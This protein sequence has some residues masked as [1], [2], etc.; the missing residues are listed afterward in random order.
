MDA[1]LAITVFFLSFDSDTGVA[2][3]SGHQGERLS[4]GSGDLRVGL[5]RITPD[6][7]DSPWSVPLS[8]GRLPGT[9][10]ALDQWPAAEQGAADDGAAGEDAGDPPQRGV[11][12]VRQRQPCQGLASFEVISA[13]TPLGPTRSPPEGGVG[14]LVAPFRRTS[15]QPPGRRPP[16]PGVP[17]Q[18]QPS[19]APGP[20]GAIH[21]GSRWWGDSLSPRCHAASA[22]SV[23]DA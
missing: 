4:P 23:T 1:D 22:R 2:D 12:A 11:V 8:P 3:V 18:R 21:S 17:A 5:G 9:V 7:W 10:C 16:R 20:A 14:G 13:P 19:H 6:E 15:R